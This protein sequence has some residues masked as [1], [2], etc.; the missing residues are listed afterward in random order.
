MLWR[1]WVILLRTGRKWACSDAQTL[2]H[3]DHLDNLLKMQVLNATSPPFH[4]P[5]TSDMVG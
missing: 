4:P 5:L 3:K 1:L 2:V